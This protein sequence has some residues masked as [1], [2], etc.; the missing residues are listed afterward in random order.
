YPTS[1]IPVFLGGVIL[2]V[3]TFVLCRRLGCGQRASCGAAVLLAMSRPLMFT[4]IIARPDI[5]CILCGV[6]GV[7]VMLSIAGSVSGESASADH[8]RWKIF[9]LLG[10][11]CGLAAL[12]HPFAL[13]FCLQAAAFAL[14][15]PGTISQ[16][17][18]RVIVLGTTAVLVAG[19]WLP[20]ILAYPDE[21]Q[22][23]FFANVLN[24]AGPGLPQRL[25]WPIPSFRNHAKLLWEFA[26]PFQCLLLIVSAV[27]GTPAVLAVG[28][29]FPTIAARTYI[30]LLWSAGYL[31][32][33]VA[34]L[35]PTKGYWLYPFV[36]ALPAF[37]M[38]CDTVAGGGHCKR[39]GRVRGIAVWIAAFALMLPGGGLKSSWLYLRHW[40]DP[41]YHAGMFIRGVLSELPREGLFLADLSYVFDVYLSGRDTLLCQDRTVH[42]G[43]RQILYS[44]LLLSWEGRNA[45]WAEQFH[46]KL[47]RSFG[48]R[49]QPQMCEVDV[50]VPAGEP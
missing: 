42:W 9:V 39:F 29:R 17:I 10:G 32:A 25:L 34:G 36:L 27:V 23:Q 33:T 8:P 48:D 22:S 4:A 5:L 19:L 21:F 16:R 7:L 26:G 43:D 46:A 3:L 30:A 1:R 40:G 11:L 38:I 20:L 13:V 24:R 2:L 6:T 12:F 47:D 18:G 28:R 49:S 44:H 35:H 31:T 41:Q 50:F 15:L 14:F 37:A 45:G